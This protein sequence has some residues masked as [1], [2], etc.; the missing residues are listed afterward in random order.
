MSNS[1]VQLQQFERNN[2]F[3]GKLLNVKDFQLEQRYMNEKRNLLNRFIHGTGV[4]G[5]LHV[6]LIDGKGFRVSPGTAIDASGREI[7]VAAN[8][9]RADIGKLA[10]YPIDFT[11]G[12]LYLS[13]QYVEVPFEPVPVVA[14]AILGKEEVAANKIRETFNLVLSKKAP[15]KGV[16]VD[17][18]YRKTVTV[19]ENSQF[20]VERT[21]PSIANPGDIVEVVLK[22]TVKQQSSGSLLVE[23]TDTLPNQ[24]TMLSGWKNNRVPFS[25]GGLTVGT[26]R[27]Q[28]Y[29]AR[30]GEQSTGGAISGN[31]LI[32]SVFYNGLNHST[33]AIESERSVARLLAEQY[34]NQLQVVDPESDAVVIAKLKINNGLITEADESVRS[35]IYN[36]ELLFEL[37]VADRQRPVE[38]PTHA[39]TH[40]SGGEDEINVS[41][42][43]GVLAEPQKIAVQDEGSELTSRAK[44]NFTGAGVVASDDPT[45]NRTNITIAGVSNVNNLP[46]TLTDPQKIV[47]QEEGTALTARSKINFIGPGVTAT[48]DSAN[49]RINVTIS[50]AASSHALSHQDGGLDKINVNNLSGT[51]ADPQ[52]VVV[53]DEGIAL[54]ARTKINFTGAG[55]TA[56]DDPTNGRINV[57]IPGG[58]SGSGTGALISSGSVVFEGVY[59]GQNV[60][61]PSIPHQLA[62]SNVAIVLGVIRTVTSGGIDTS[63]IGKLE[64][65][66]PDKLSTVE[67]LDTVSAI[68]NV[69]PVINA[70]VL[71]KLKTADK[72]T[73]IV[74][75]ADKLDVISGISPSIAVTNPD[76]TPYPG[77]G[78]I[79]IPISTS[80]MHFGDLS[81]LEPELPSV[82]AT[83]EINSPTTF[84]ITLQDRRG[85]AVQAEYGVS[86]TVTWWAFASTTYTGSITVSSGLSSSLQKGVTPSPSTAQTL[87]ASAEKL[88]VNEAVQEAVT[89]AAVETVKKTTTRKTTKDTSTPTTRST[90]SPEEA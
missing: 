64:T 1:P 48:D 28:R 43:S 46:G 67:K 37:L 11:S 90:D 17:T 10:G 7:V 86:W 44:I 21:V 22:T 27:T 72:L 83:Y 88:A 59:P 36:N 73:D 15:D 69:T 79:V 6:T 33:I 81:Y 29:Y 32:N 24:F 34:F 82:M 39:A 20:I 77:P 31:V 57:T 63:L 80:T 76:P 45:N 61:S 23:V 71:D 55:V 8:E 78:P 14:N 13:L 70:D 5:G 87:S 3:Y 60:V 54:T 38:L 16:P 42:L 75:P 26:V 41:N 2:Y 4:I 58:G 66:I 50:G 62:S 52:K 65:T 53:Q 49:G 74:L 18:Q 9:D 51:L 47:V 89:E 30:A 19:Y 40:G 12:D 35:F 85:L 56:V 84:T 68:D 25:L